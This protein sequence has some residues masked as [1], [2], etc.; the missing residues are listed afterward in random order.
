[1]SGA[2]SPAPVRPVV[3][4]MLGAFWPGN[5][6]SGPNQSFMALAKALGDEFEFRLLARDQ[7]FPGSAGFPARSCHPNYVGSMSPDKRLNSGLESPRSREGINDA[8]VDLGYAKARYCEIGKTG[9]T[10]LRQI[11]RQ[12][13]HDLLW[14]NG[15]FDREFTL[16][17]L[18]LRRLRLVPPAPALLSPRGEFGAGALGLKSGRKQAFLKLARLSGAL[19]GIAL[20]ATSATEAAEIAT[21]TGSASAIIIA[22]NIRGLVNAPPFVPP[23]TPALRVAFVGRISPVKQLDYALDVLK[24]VQVPVEFSI[25]GPVQ[26]AAYWQACQQKIAALPAHVRATWQGETANEAIVAALAQTDLF[27]LPTAGENFGHAIFEALSCGVPALISD[28]TPWRGLAA[29]QAGW[30]LPLADQSRF[31]AVMD[32][33]ASLPEAARAILRQGARA[34][35]EQSVRDSGAIEASRAMLHSLLLPAGQGR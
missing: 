1:M 27:F 32:D 23:P 24:H 8:W 35:A 6:A 31:A 28:T 17:A 15:F 9:A 18:L 7:P 2:G 22:P 30:D 14:M 33:F 26:D 11:L 3:L 12:T 21:S 34:R 5:E 10:G 20:H 4:V 25:Y 29:M 13:P 16:P 19:R